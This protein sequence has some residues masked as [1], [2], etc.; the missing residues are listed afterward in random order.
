MPPLQNQ[1]NTRKAM[2]MLIIQAHDFCSFKGA[3]TLRAIDAKLL[4]ITV[5][6]HEQKINI[7]IA[8]FLF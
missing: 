6:K 5:L 7:T 4:Q 2:T 8:Y 1:K 3:S